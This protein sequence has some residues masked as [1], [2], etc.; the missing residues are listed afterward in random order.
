[1]TNPMCNKACMP[2]PT[3]QPLR[4]RSPRSQV[5]YSDRFI[6]SRA[7]SSRLNFSVFDRETA[8]SEIQKPPD[9]DVRFSSN[10]AAKKHDVWHRIRHVR[11][12]GFAPSTSVLILLLVTGKIGGCCS[13]LSVVPRQLAIGQH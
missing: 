6:P 9:K 5:T 3:P 11:R 1:M 10:A 4:C 7:A 8:T 13:R 2:T 12:L